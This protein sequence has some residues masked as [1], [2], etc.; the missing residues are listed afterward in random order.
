MKIKFSEDINLKKSLTEIKLETTD[1]V[2]EIEKIINENP[3]NRMNQQKKDYKELKTKWET[4]I[5]QIKC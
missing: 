1:L 5:T 3:T 2:S 4:L